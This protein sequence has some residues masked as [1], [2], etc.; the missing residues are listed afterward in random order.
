ME[1]EI[2]SHFNNESIQNIIEEEERLNKVVIGPDTELTSQTEWKRWLET[3]LDS[4]SGNLDNAAELMTALTQGKNYIYDDPA[5]QG[6]K[7]PQTVL[8][9]DNRLS[10]ST[11]SEYR[12]KK[13]L[14]KKSGLENLSQYAMAAVLPIKNGAGK[15]IFE[16]TLP[17]YFRLV[18]LEEADHTAF[19]QTE[20]FV[21][22]GVDPLSV[23][24]DVYDARN[25]EF[26]ALQ[27]KV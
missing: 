10:A 22:P 23:P 1:E 14:V 7:R 17:D 5:T 6:L 12:G 3:Q 2:N 19:E 24:E 13:I 27:K 26:R 20:T 4:F 21:E 8:L 16:G 9:L 11:I 25:I 18:G 15:V